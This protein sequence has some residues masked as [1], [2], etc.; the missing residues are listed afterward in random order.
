MKKK[1]L[2]KILWYVFS[3][4]IAIIFLLP[5]YIAVTDSFKTQKGLYMDT[6]GLPT[7]AVFTLENYVQAF[8]DLNFFKSFL[9]SLTITVIS[10]VLIIIFTSITAWVLVRQKTK[11]S[12]FIFFLFALAMLVPFQA[13]MLPLVHIMGKLH[14]LNPGGLI[15]MYIG[16]GS[17]LSIILYHGFIKGIP[18]ELEEAATIDGCNKFQIFWFIVF[19]LL[20]PI[21]VTVS[22][23]NS[24]WIWNDF[25]LPQ[26]VINK[27]E[28]QTIP[29]KMFYFFGQY[30]KKW[31][32]A[33]A[34]LVISIIPMIVFYFLAQK[35]IVKGIT[36]GS[37]K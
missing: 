8:I 5:I 7:K 11:M 29:L 24:M 26:L 23:L 33:L 18:V 14:L 35:H 2:K 15:F 34:G 4:I 30:A 6:I 3:T 31:N 28:W 10:T 1:T 12:K 19:P 17:S 37:I 22:I 20:K 21:T 9:N 25:L 32:L 13:V 16:F 27:P 36:Q